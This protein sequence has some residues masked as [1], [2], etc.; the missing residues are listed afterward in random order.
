METSIHCVVLRGGTSRGLYFL[1]DDLPTD[2]QQ[3]DRTLLQIMGAP[4]VL[5]VNGLGGG[6]SLTS[7]VAIISRSQRPGCDVDYLFAQVGIEQAIV[8]TRPNCGNLLSGVGPYAIEEGIVVPNDGVT[9]VRIYNINAKTVVEAEIQTP[10]KRVTYEGD[11]RIDGVP[12]TGA[13]IILNFLNVQGG[14]T[15]A[16]FPTGS[17]IDQIGGVQATCIDAAIPVMI[18]D[19][20]AL[21]VSGAEPAEV[22]DANTTLMARLESLRLEAG[23]LM[24]LGDVTDSVL[25]KPVI[26]SPAGPRAIQSRYFTPHR[27][28]K[29]HAV[30]GAISVSASFVIPGTLTYGMCADHTDDRRISILHPAGQIDIALDVQ[31][32]GEKVHIARAGV[33]RTARKIMDGTAFIHETHALDDMT[34]SAD[35]SA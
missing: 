34:L 27:C 18:V 26:A 24:G 9:L 33:I 14:V 28:H 11:A 29:S 15:G 6:N 21:G 25:P 2:R 23:Q 35:E 10:N 3:R 1:A 4:H 32:D 30:T 19:A 5:E 22:L 17:R 13:P 8:D 31:L 12:G 20:Q 16:L 7:K